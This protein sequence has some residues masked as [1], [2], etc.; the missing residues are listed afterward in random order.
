M[1]DKLN[2]IARDLFHAIF[3]DMVFMGTVFSI[4]SVIVSTLILTQVETNAHIN[5]YNTYFPFISFFILYLCYTVYLN[6]K[7]K[8]STLTKTALSFYS[9]LL[10]SY[11][12]VLTYVLAKCN[13]DIIDATTNLVP[14][15]YYSPL[16][17]I[18]ITLSFN[19][20]VVAIYTGI[21]L[22]LFLLVL[23]HCI[24]L[25]T[26]RA[27]PVLIISFT[28]GGSCTYMYCN[29]DSAVVKNEGHGFEYM[30]GYS[31]TDFTGYHVYDGE[32][33][34]TLDH[35]PSLYI[36][37]KNKMPVFDGAEAC[38]PLYCSIAKAIY[39]DISAI[40]Y[41]IQKNNT[42]HPY[43]RPQKGIINF[44]NTVY[45]YKSL[46]NG[47][48]DIFFGARPSK[49]QIENALNNGQQIIST[50][51]GKEAFVFFVEVDNPVNDLS[52]EDIKNIYSGKITNWKKLGGKNQKIYAFQRPENSGSQVV[53]KRIM[54]DTP[55]KTP[56][57]NE[58][59]SGMGGVIR[60]VAKY[61]GASGS[62]GYSFRYFVEELHQEENVKLLSINGINPTLENI[63]NGTYP[64]TA[65]LVCAHLESNKKPEVKQ[66][67]DFIKSPD[68]QYIIKKTGYA[69][70]NGEDIF[71]SN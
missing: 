70:F 37:D 22:L 14:F 16:G 24:F 12:G 49:A 58:Y 25:K 69:P 13:G 65:E 50:P 9:I 31:S 53:M 52:V 68:G 55:L 7:K 23:L 43:N 46:I 41:Q 61:N 39:K 63:E 40:E 11:A 38:Y 28:L 48:C 27:I 54:G 29:R 6:S 26:G 36:T 20:N 42:D 19:G 4:L 64:L 8:R 35:T 32:K 45:G 60:S 34:V 44:T 10:I 51:I 62:I 1:K 18:D 57:R 59:V 15:L 66:V 21:F 3:V 56:I 30:N 47:E 67:L 17:A 2:I 33:L 5:V 71:E